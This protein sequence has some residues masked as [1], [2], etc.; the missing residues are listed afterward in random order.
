VKSEPYA[1]RFKDGKLTV[2]DPNEVKE[3]SPKGKS[4]A[5]PSGSPNG[6]FAVLAQI[7]LTKKADLARENMKKS[8]MG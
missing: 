1:F 8:R 6:G 7:L 3:K 4:T 2:I 5:G